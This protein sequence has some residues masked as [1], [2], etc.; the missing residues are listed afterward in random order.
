MEFQTVGKGLP[1][2][3][4]ERVGPRFFYAQTHQG[5]D[6]AAKTGKVHIRSRQAVYQQGR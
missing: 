4:M 5:Q 6:I 1:H 3:A 2:I